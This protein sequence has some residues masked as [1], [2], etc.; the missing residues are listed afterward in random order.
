[1]KQVN[2]DLIRKVAIGVMRYEASVAKRYRVSIQRLRKAMHEAG[3]A[4]KKGKVRVSAT[5][6]K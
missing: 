2:E 6:T 4:P 5:A 1:M 3:E